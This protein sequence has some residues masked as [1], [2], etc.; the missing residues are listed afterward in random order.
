MTFFAVT[1][2]LVSLAMSLGIIWCVSEMARLVTSKTRTGLFAAGACAL[3]FGL[4]YYGQ[5]SNLDVPYLFWGLL[6]L[7]WGMRAVMERAPRR[8]WGA[9]LFAAAAVAT[10]DQA[11]ALFALAG[12]HAV[13]ALYHQFVRR[14]GILLRMMPG[15]TG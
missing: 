13:G 8:L 15:G 11:Y 9:A 5:V 12:L 10:K 14:D 4:T 3:G 6:A 7:L 2:R 1:G